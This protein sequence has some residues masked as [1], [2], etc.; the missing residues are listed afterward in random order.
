MVHVGHGGAFGTDAHLRIIEDR[1]VVL[2]I[3]TPGA[4]V[5]DF[6]TAVRR[7]LRDVFD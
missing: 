5:R 7:A 3:Q 2:I 4:Q 6:Q 1:I